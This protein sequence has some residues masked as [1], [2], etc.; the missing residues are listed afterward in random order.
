MP[1][2]GCPKKLPFS[3]QDNVSCFDLVLFFVLPNFRRSA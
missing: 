1:Y 3:R 2:L